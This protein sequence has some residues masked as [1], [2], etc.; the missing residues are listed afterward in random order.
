[1]GEQQQN[2]KTR[3]KLWRA[4]VIEKVQ[5]TIQHGSKLIEVINV[6]HVRSLSVIQN[7]SRRVQTE[8]VTDFFRS[9]FMTFEQ[10]LKL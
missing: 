6:L 4:P 7:K 10:F 9:A 8:T 3:G 5:E 1:M 2:A